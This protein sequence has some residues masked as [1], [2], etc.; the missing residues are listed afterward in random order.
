MATMEKKPVTSGKAGPGLKGQIIPDKAMLINRMIQILDRS[1]S[2][3]Q[4]LQQAADALAQSFKPANNAYAR[5][6]YDEQVVKSRR[7]EETEV[8]IKRRFQ[9]PGNEQV[10]VELFLPECLMQT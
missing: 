5:V 3:S 4:S 6:S 10:L 8:V 7:F 2:L 1:R 9:L